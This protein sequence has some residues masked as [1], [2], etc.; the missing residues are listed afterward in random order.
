M[1]RIVADQREVVP[2]LSSPL[3]ESPLHILRSADFKQ[4]CLLV[5]G[6]WARGSEGVED[7]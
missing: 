5:L 4:D 2:A 7:I 1:V 6:I 3:V